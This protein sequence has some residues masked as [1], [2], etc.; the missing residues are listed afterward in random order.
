MTMALNPSLSTDAE[1]LFEFHGDI[2]S[3]MIV[4]R[5]GNVVAFASRTRRPVDPAFIRD[6]ASK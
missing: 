3:V 6:V 5:I 2:R 4:D 1:K